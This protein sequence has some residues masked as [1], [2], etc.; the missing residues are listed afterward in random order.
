MKYIPQG[1]SVV[2]W[3]QAVDGREWTVVVASAA[4]LPLATR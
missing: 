4:R 3:Q 1:L 2:V